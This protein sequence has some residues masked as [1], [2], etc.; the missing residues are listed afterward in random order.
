MATYRNVQGG[1]IQSLSSDPTSPVNGE[2]WYNTTSNTF[3]FRGQLSSNSWAAGGSLITQPPS[4]Q[5]MSYMCG[6]G[7]R[8]ATM[9]VGG[10]S[11]DTNLSQTY[12][13]TS[14]T[15]GPNMT[16]TITSTGAVSS[17]ST[18]PSSQ[19]S[20]PAILGGDNNNPT[21]VLSFNWD[22]SSFSNNPASMTARR[23]GPWAFGSGV[24]TA[25]FWGGVGTPAPSPNYLSSGEVYNGTAFSASPATLNT[26]RGVGTGGQMGSGTPNSAIIATGYAPAM[27]NSESFNGT[28]WSNTSPT[29]YAR[30]GA[31]MIGDSGTYALV[32]T[33]NSGGTPAVGPGPTGTIGAELWDGSSWSNT[34]NL[35]NFKQYSTGSGNAGIGFQFG[36]DT[37]GTATPLRRLT[38]EWTGSYEATVTVQGS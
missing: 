37:G 10:N 21:G 33:G 20:G 17:R 3:K 27:T 30:Y 32:F 26:A 22:G 28:A 2:V 19:A 9:T 34:T 16:E 5:E 4:H 18:T 1:T 14:W 6:F 31:A 24:P 29:N 23:A 38:E 36:G 8:S 7:N 15:A 11:P 35:S 25:N 13:D 12:N